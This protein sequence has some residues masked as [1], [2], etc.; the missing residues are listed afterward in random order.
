MQVEALDA[1]N[2]RRL[3][4]LEPR[5]VPLEQVRA[6]GEQPLLVTANA[7]LLNV[8]RDHRR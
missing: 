6:T 5:R 1:S 3:P 4:P 2:L 7:D 8:P